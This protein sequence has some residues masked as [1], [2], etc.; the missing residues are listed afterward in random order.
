[1]RGSADHDQ[2]ALDRW[3]R[4]V[5]ASGRGTKGKIKSLIDKYLKKAPDGAFKKLLG[6]ID[7][8]KTT[9]ELDKLGD[10]SSGLELSATEI[11]ELKT[12][13]SKKVARLRTKTYRGY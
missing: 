6:D 5:A 1:M 2:E 8:A 7:R 13:V 3:D 9:E 12:V 10:I 4:S 11:K